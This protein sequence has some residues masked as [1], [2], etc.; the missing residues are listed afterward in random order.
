VDFFCLPYDS[1][2]RQHKS[3][4]IYGPVLENGWTSTVTKPTVSHGVNDTL[5][6]KIQ[7]ELDK[8]IA[9]HLEKGLY[10]LKI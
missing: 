1:I 7:Q 6:T 10:D 8:S 4:S 9:K 5:S 2:D 3:G